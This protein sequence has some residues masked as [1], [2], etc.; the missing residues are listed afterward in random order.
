[1]TLGV[2][3]RQ[4]TDTQSQDVHG[5]SLLLP[6]AGQYTI[7]FNVNLSTWDTYTP[8]QGNGTGYWDAFS[9]SITSA[10]LYRPGDVYVRDQRR[11]CR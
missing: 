7:Y 6:A 9:V 8:Y 2:A 1:V 3:N 10:A 5:A 11:V 4:E